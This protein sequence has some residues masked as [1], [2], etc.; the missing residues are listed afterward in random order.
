MSKRVC[1]KCGEE[2]DPDETGGAVDGED[3]CGDCYSDSR[4]VCGLCEESYDG[5]ASDGDLGRIVVFYP[6]N[7]DHHQRTLRSGWYRVR[8]WPF[9]GGD[10]I[11]SAYFFSDALEFIGPLWPGDRKRAG[12]YDSALVCEHCFAGRER[13]LARAARA[14]GDVRDGDE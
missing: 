8:R 11:G 1:P 7:A 5:L 3:V 6:T 2:Y 14:A 9:H 12:D 10:M 4:E 13:D